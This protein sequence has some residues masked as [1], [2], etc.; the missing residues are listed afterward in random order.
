MREANPQRNRDMVCF[1]FVRIAGYASRTFR[2]RRCMQSRRSIAIAAVIAL[3]IVWGSTFVITKAA[4][5]DV[6]PLALA[7]LRFLV[8]SVVLI[9]IAMS[10]G[11]LAI[12]PRPIPWGTLTLMAFTG[13][14]AF[15][16]TFTYALVYGSAAQGALIYAALPAAIAVA[17]VLFLAERPTRR[18]IAGIALS[19]AGVVLLVLTGAPDAE[20]P[21]PVLGAL[22]MLG[23]VAA[24]TIYTVIAKRM[25]DADPVVTIAIV[26]TIGTLL[27]LPPA[28]IELTQQP[29]TM[30]SMTS[31]AAV[32]FLGIVASALAYLVYAFV[33][34]ELDAS[35]VG[36]YTNLDP[37]V[38]VLIAVLFFGEVLHTGQV[39]GGLLALAGMWLASAEA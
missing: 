33:L 39:I 5:R 20:S 18:R 22:W 17:A 11:G 21:S 24:W 28:A 30:P 23:A 31:W 14:T 8:A 35:L 1:A 38:G 9:P 15:A 27:L 36:V 25:A 37:I 34:R 12:L 10:R 4:A 7:A 6:P 13:I 26:S 32:L 2:S 29:W 19:I 3:M 16:I